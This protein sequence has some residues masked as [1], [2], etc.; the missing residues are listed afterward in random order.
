M[1]GQ[2]DFLQLGSYLS[3]PIQMSRTAL[4]TLCSSP[5]LGD[6]RDEGR[7]YC[8]FRASPSFTITWSVFSVEVVVPTPQRH[9]TCATILSFSG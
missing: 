1:S 5:S 4:G 6:G 9:A 2:A 7:D 8:P 3:Q